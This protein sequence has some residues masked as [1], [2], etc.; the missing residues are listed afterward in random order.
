MAETIISLL[1]PTLDIKS[2]YYFNPDYLH[3]FNMHTNTAIDKLSEAK[4]NYGIWKLRFFDLLQ[5]TN[6][7]GFIDGT[8]PK[9]DPSSPY[10]EPWKQCNAIVLHWLSNTV[11]DTL[12]NHVLQAETVHKA[13][14]DLR[15]IFVPCIDFK[16][17][18]LR[19]RL[20]TLRQGGDSVAEYFG[21]L[22]KAWL[23]LKAYDP[24]QECKCGGCDCESEKRATE[25]RE[26][27][28]R[29]AFLMGLNKEFDYV[30]MKVMHKKIPPSVY[31]AYEMVVYSEA[32]MKWK[33][34]GRI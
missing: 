30:K 27:E 26:K 2:P 10:Y 6:K 34:G 32:M 3:Q 14:E 16:I 9:P 1:S 8:L 18:E 21:K 11:T 31:Q 24:V 28:Q 15:R 23:E 17:Y 22:S 25:A 13:W 7:T 19:Q 33:M 12:Q 4:D 5:F 20:A 29:Y